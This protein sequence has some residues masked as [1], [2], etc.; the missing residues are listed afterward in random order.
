MQLWRW[1]AEGEQ[2]FLCFIVI[3]V[4]VILSF[5]VFCSEFSIRASGY[6]L[7]L[8]GMVYAI[9][10]L[11]CIRKYFRHP[12]LRKL[13]LDW[14]KRF[15]KWKRKI[16]FAGGA[17]A[18][19]EARVEGRGEVWTPDN[20]NKTIEQRIDDLI[21][22]LETLRNQLRRHDSIIDQLKTSHEEHKKKVAQQARKFEEDIRSD[23]ETIHTSDWIT[24]LVGLV[25][26]TVGITMSTMAPELYQ[27]LY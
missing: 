16:I 4:A 24:S 27:L 18:N 25:G 6:L 9:K 13:F 10:G 3:G 12:L 21:Q 22:N 15:P 23:L 14:L 1:L 17:V 19:V 20:P 7:Q 26:L 5:F 2:I 11:L 8:V